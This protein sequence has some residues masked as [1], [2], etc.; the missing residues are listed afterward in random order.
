MWGYLLGTN[1]LSVAI[2]PVSTL[3]ETI[4]QRQRA[5]VRFGTCIPVL[6][7]LE[8]AVQHSSHTDSY[9]RQLHKVLQ[10]VRLWPL[11]QATAR[12]YGEIYLDLRQRG[13][14]LS[15]VDIMLAALAKRMSL[16]ILTTDRDFEALPH[17]RTENW[18][19]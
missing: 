7:E 15:Q 4:Y 13:R 11:D 16:I 5:G 8:V 19:I 18:T 3:R 17:I 12:L 9:R 2:N 1:H 6:C 14:M 10:R